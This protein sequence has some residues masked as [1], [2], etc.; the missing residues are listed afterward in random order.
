MQVVAG[1]RQVGKTTLVTQALARLG[2]PHVFVSADEPTL[3]DGAW[4]AA[5]WE[6][7]RAEASASPEGAI[8]AI[9]EVQKAPHWSETVK[10]LWDEDGRRG[11]ALHVVLLG[12]SPLLVQQGLTE[13]LA[14]RFE[15]VR[16]PHWSLTEMR[17]AFGFDLEAYLSVRRLPRRGTARRRPRTLAAVPPRRADR[18]DDRARRAAHDPGGQA[19]PPAPHVRARL[20]VLRPD[21]VLHEDARPAPGGRQ[22]HHPRPLP[23]AAGRRGHADRPVE[24]R[25]GGRPPARLQPQAPGVQHGADVRDRGTGST[26]R[27]ESR[28]SAAASPSRPSAPIW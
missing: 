20:P 21:P 26:P 2:V 3:R 18:D 5:Q 10:R 1:P 22:H 28:R 24:V 14:G 25:G 15:I 6:R 23:R 9:D 11:L 7:A 27:T 17:A 13:S 19:R 12:S 4:L 8:L 16:A